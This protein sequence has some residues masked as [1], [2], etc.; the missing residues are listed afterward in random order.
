ME[1]V[2]HAHPEI[3]WRQKHPWLYSSLG[4]PQAPVWFIAENPSDKQIRRVRKN[5][6]EQQ[7]AASAN[8]RLFREALYRNDFKTGSPMSPGGWNCYITNI[9]KA[10]VVVGEWNGRPAPDRDVQVDW[11]APVLKYEMLSGAPRLIVTMGGQAQRHFNRFRRKGWV[12]A[13]PSCR[14][15]WH[16]AFRGKTALRKAEY[17]RQFEAVRKAAAQAL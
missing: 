3:D 5:D 8:D 7:W 15:V 10:P 9:A 2:L 14:H 4:D 12:P 1:G 13:K 11:W 17:Y 6:A 16:Y